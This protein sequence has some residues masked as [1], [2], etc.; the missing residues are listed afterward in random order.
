M[1]DS[2]RWC[3]FSDEVVSPEAERDSG[4]DL[5]CSVRISRRREA[6]LWR[7][8]EV[9][10]LSLVTEVSSHASCSKINE[11]HNITRKTTYLKRKENARSSTIEKIFV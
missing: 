2:D 7:A 6:A 10:Q 8:V 1:A 11:F 5:I 4:G 3:C 9:R